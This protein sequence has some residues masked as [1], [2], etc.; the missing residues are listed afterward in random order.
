VSLRLYPHNDLGS[1]ASVVAEMREQARLGVQAGFDGVMTSEHHGG[2]AGYSP[3]PLQLA[4]W[5][6]EA[7]P[8]GWAAA[9]PLLLPLR[10]V[11]LVAEEV[12]WLAARFPG[13]VAVGVAPGALALDFSVAS[14]DFEERND[15]FRSGLPRL[16]G[17]LRG[18]ELDDLAGDLALQACADDP[19]T[20][21]ATALSPGAVRRAARCG[22]GIV[23]DGASA[24]ERLGSL[25]ADYDEAGGSGPKVLIR[26]VWLGDPPREAFD[27]QTD[28]Y[29][30]YSSSS[31]QSHWRDNGFLCRDDPAELAADLRAAVD[32][33]G[34]TCL[35]LRIHVPGVSPEMARAQIEALGSS[36]P[37]I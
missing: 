7:M 25:S 28:V 9:C 18:D 1:A 17:L 6:L 26:R 30:S 13:R 23:Y 34:A 35:N 14:A 19:I 20:V 31:A 33:A 16:A 29:R 2:F 11:G 37:L 15:R 32:A 36:L 8:S 12:A 27:R 5:L 3:N 4:G 21:I 22:A 10:S 24:V